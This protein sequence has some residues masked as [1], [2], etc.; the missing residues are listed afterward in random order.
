MYRWVQQTTVI[1]HHGMKP[2]LADVVAVQ[3]CLAVIYQ[4]ALACSVFMQFA[5]FLCLIRLPFPVL[6]LYAIASPV[7]PVYRRFEQS[8]GKVSL[9]FERPT[10]GSS[11]D[12]RGM[13]VNS[14]LRLIVARGT[15]NDITS[16]SGYHG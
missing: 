12:D 3:D 8:G 9:E 16:F 14:P 10:A 1:F 15:S 11:D 4:P 6:S 13:P 7:C 2:I 5:R